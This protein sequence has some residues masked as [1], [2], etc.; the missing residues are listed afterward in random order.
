MAD[1]PTAP[2]MQGSILALANLLVNF[3]KKQAAISI[4]C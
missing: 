1:P 4:T 3:F 2:Q